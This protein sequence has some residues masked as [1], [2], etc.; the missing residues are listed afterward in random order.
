[1]GIKNHIE[2]KEYNVV[3]F[4]CIHCDFMLRETGKFEDN[5]VRRPADY[6]I[7]AKHLLDEHNI[8][9]GD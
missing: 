3:E 4:C 7:I 2:I 9:I 6:D 1:M 8:K 5:W